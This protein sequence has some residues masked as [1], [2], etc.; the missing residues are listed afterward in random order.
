VLQEIDQQLL[1]SKHILTFG[2]LMHL[3]LD[4]KQYVVSKVSPN[5]QP[6][7]PQAPPFD[8][9]SVIINPH[10][11]VI[12]VHVGKNLMED[13]MLDGG[14]SVNIIIKDLKKKLT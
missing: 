2:Q 3:A 12:L 14:S 8:V 7:H 13:V 1:S 4:L 5:S 10:M 9:R 6:T 11:V